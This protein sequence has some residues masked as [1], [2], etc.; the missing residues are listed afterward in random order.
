M[1]KFRQRTYEYKSF[2]QFMNKREDETELEQW[3]IDMM[4]SQET[5]LP[6]ALESTVLIRPDK[7]VAVEEAYTLENIQLNEDPVPDCIKI[8]TETDEW[9]CLTTLKDFE[10][11]FSKY[12][13]STEN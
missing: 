8:S 2:L 4:E 5:Q 10:K 6:K 7:V 12:G 11:Q 3:Q 1:L 9:L 13:G